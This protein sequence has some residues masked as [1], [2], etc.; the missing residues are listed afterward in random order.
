[1]SI[2]PL[3]PGWSLS[4]ELRT[5]SRLDR[6]CLWDLRRSR[7][8]MWWGRRRGG[9]AAGAGRAWLL[10]ADRL[11]VDGARGCSEYVATFAVPTDEGGLPPGGAGVGGAGGWRGAAGGGHRGADSAD[12][13]DDHGAAAAGLLGVG[14]PDVSASGAGA[15]SGSRGGR[16]LRDGRWRL[17]AGV[18][19]ASAV[20]GGAMATVLLVAR[21]RALRSRRVT[22]LVGFVAALVIWLFMWL[23][24]TSACRSF[25]GAHIGDTEWSDA[26]G[27]CRTCLAFPFRGAGWAAP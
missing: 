27:H 11:R 6:S 19:G 14:P 13:T 18:G 22:A 25:T 3:L 20:L 17:A 2:G 7:R 16:R 12:A 26:D 5:P 21:V 24:R 23:R 10:W 9:G 1:M 8:R 15:T 4:Q